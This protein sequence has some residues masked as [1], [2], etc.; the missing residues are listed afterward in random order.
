MTTIQPMDTNGT[1]T[2]PKQYQLWL[3]HEEMHLIY[4]ALD[5]AYISRIADTSNMSNMVAFIK[6]TFGF[7][8][9]YEKLTQQGVE[10]FADRFDTVHKQARADDGETV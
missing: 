4:W 8:K 10:A 2:G 6:A 7:D 3:S 1:V 9:V 5:L